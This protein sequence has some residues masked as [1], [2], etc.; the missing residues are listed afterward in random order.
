[1]QTNPDAYYLGIGSV[2]SE[3]ITSKLTTNGDGYWTKLLTSRPKNW[4]SIVGMIKSENAKGVLVKLTGNDYERIYRPE[5][6]EVAEAIFSALSTVPNIVL[7]HENVVGMPDAA[8]TNPVQHDEEGAADDD[9]DYDGGEWNDKVAREH[10]GDVDESA[11]KYVHELLDR[12]GISVT[13]YRRNAELSVLATSFVDDLQ[14]NLLFR[15]YVPAGRIYEEELAKLL[16]LFHEWLGSVK[17]QTVRKDGYQTKS[18]RVIEFFSDRSPAETTWNED[19]SEFSAFFDLVDTPDVATKMLLALGVEPERAGHLVFRY[20]REVRRVRLDTK[21]ERERRMLQIQQQLEAELLDDPM[22]VSTDVLDEMVKR[23]VPVSPLG[24]SSSS[25][26]SIQSQGNQTPTVL[27]QQQIFQR[28]EGVVAQ[29]IQGTVNVGTPLGDVIGL[30]REYGGAH[31]EDLENAARELAD[32][33]A[34]PAARLG[35]RQ[36]IKAFLQRNAVRIEGAAFNTAWKWVESQIG[37]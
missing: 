34:P 5:Y 7:V 19:L 27:I 12:H 18:G 20:S 32:Q 21:Q 9:Y 24:S 10:F 23:L 13:T 26:L 25:P 36:K 14:N 37:G 8:V 4:R 35:A 30:I 33:G 28:V 31:L 11:R 29:N 17:G 6:K 22:L 15:L 3:S 16:S 1:M 2:M